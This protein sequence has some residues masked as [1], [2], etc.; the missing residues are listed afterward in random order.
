MHRFAVFG[1]ATL[2]AC[3]SAP[4]SEGGVLQAMMAAVNAGDAHAYAE[5]Y[6]E[7]AVIAIH[8]TGEVRGRAAIE[9]HEVDLLRQYPGARFAIYDAWRIDGGARIVAHY[10]VS[11]TTPDGKKMGHEGLLFFRLLPTGAIAEEHRYQDALTPMAQLGLLPGLEARPVP[12]LPATMRERESPGGSLSLRPD[13]HAWFAAWDAGDL[14]RNGAVPDDVVV[15][16]LFDARPGAGKAEAQALC[17]AWHRAVPD[18]TT[19]ITWEHRSANGPLLV[20]AEVTGTL[21]G[22][23]G[24]LR[25]CGRRFTIHRAAIFDGFNII[26]CFNR[27]ELA[28]AVGQWPPGIR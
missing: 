26:D 14:L 9:Q 7:D 21:Q 15:D 24:P 27:K 12:R 25:G 19:T 13:G 20:E 17:A 5:L 8:G 4:S 11:C 22:D 2:A 23:V 6:S 28:M 16:A 1:L 18:A 10:G 3:S